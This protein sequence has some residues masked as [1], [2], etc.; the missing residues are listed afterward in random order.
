MK[1][2]TEGICEWCLFNVAYE[3]IGSCW[4]VD[5][6]SKTWRIFL[7]IDI[8]SC[9]S[10]PLQNLQWSLSKLQIRRR[11][12]GQTSWP[13]SPRTLPNLEYLRC[14]VPSWS[15]DYTSAEVNRSVETSGRTKEADRQNYKEMDKVDLAAF[16]HLRSRSNL[17]QLLSS[18]VSLRKFGKFHT[19]FVDGIEDCRRTLKDT[20]L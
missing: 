16:P 13:E 9:S 4:R 7:W 17:R 14:I 11:Q 5:Q 2:I 6:E 10:S 1:Q 18:V 12:H 19:R 3:S 15:H 20:N 8:H